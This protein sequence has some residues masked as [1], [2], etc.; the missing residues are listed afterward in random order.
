[1]GQND[2]LLEVKGPY[3]TLDPTSLFWNDGERHSLPY[4]FLPVVR[5][6]HQRK[7]ARYMMCK[8]KKEL[9]CGF[10]KSPSGYC[11]IWGQEDDSV[12]SH[13]VERLRPKPKSR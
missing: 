4:G 10:P 9:E 8:T 3:R 2:S 6:A 7:P 11:E 12:I 1:M 13:S 5:Q